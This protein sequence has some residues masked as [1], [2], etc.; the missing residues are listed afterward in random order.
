M[1][2]K[3]QLKEEINIEKEKL[4]NMSFRDKLW[5]IGEYYKFHIFGLLIVIGI[6]SMIGF[7]IYQGTYDTALYCMYIN[8]HSEQE[9][10]TD[11]LTID[12]HDYMGF[13]EKQVINTES[14]FISY[15]DD[16]TEFSYASMAKI[17]ALVASKE[18]DIMISD[19]ANFNH[20]ASLG[21]FSDLEAE[22]PADVL[23]LVADRLVYAADESGIK[24][25]YG[26]SLDDTQ[27]AADSNL[28]MKPALFGIVSNSMHRENNIQ[29]L[30]YIFEK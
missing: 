5:Y 2:A 12:F 23:E 22:L 7:S 21:G 9:L 3:E 10:N 25:A 26:I 28:A 30:R 1:S 24:R 16:A 27:F 13:N 11:I 4:K 8:N 17:S 29:L 6:I 20:Y 19:E 14:V 18:L 15:G